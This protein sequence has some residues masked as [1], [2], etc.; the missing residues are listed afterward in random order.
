[1]DGVGPME[2][3]DGKV[4]VTWMPLVP[5]IDGIEGSTTLDETLSPEMVGGW[6]NKEKGPLNISPIWTS[7]GALGSVKGGLNFCGVLFLTTSTS[8]KP[9]SSNQI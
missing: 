5:L 6:L 4:D 9:L 3:R 2:L 8:T 1:M 7:R